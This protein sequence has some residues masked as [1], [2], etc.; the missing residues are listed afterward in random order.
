MLGD[1]IMSI[2]GIY[3]R[4]GTEQIGPF[5]SRQ[6]AERFLFLMELFGT[7]IEGIKIVELEIAAVPPSAEYSTSA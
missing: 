2:L 6:D 1:G 7:S 3:L 4:E 5:H